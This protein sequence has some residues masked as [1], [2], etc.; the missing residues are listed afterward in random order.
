MLDKII[1]V[2]KRLFCKHDYHFSHNIY[3]DEIN[4]HG[5]NRSWH[6]CYVCGDWKTFPN[7]GTMNPNRIGEL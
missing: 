3:G 1:Y 4:H 7:L 2:L 5:G 6:K